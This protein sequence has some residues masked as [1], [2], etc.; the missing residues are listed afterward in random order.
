MLLMVESC[1][2]IESTVRPEKKGIG[3]FEN[4]GDSNLFLRNGI[5]TISKVENTD[6]ELKAEIESLIDFHRARAERHPKTF[7]THADANPTNILVKGDRV[8]G[9]IDFEM[10]GFYPEYWEWTTATNQQMDDLW[11][12][13]LCDRPY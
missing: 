6:E 13:I 5:E 10:S 11:R 2:I 7:L 3:P 4:E 1:T 8:V 9:L 12:K